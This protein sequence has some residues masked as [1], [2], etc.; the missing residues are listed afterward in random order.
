MSVNAYAEIDYSELGKHA[1]PSEVLQILRETPLGDEHAQPF[2]VL[3]HFQKNPKTNDAQ[4]LEAFDIYRSKVPLRLYSLM[5]RGCFLEGE[6]FRPALKQRLLQEGR[7]HLEAQL[8]VDEKERLQFLSSLG[9]YLTSIDETKFIELLEKVLATL[10]RDQHWLFYEG[11]AISPFA[12]NDIGAVVDAFE[13]KNSALHKFLDDYSWYQTMVVLHEQ[14][15]RGWAPQT[16]L[17]AESLTEVLKRGDREKQAVAL[18]NIGTLGAYLGSSWAAI[19]QVPE[20]LASEE[21]GRALN[22]LYMQADAAEFFGTSL[23]TALS[24]TS[25]AD[26]AKARIDEQVRQESD[27]RTSALLQALDDLCE[28]RSEAD[29]E[30]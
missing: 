30:N 24:F 7:M 15:L 5:L 14:L 28:K 3:R 4:L 29:R 1:E 8:G 19:R 12:A 6:R 13:A 9:S 26:I 27:Q 25:Y 11:V 21:L 17:L 22:A 16:A 10:P 2:M 20:L 23:H 18:A